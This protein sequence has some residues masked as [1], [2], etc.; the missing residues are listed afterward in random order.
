MTLI[1]KKSLENIWNVCDGDVDQIINRLST[2]EKRRKQNEF[3]EAVKEFKTAVE[4]L[5]TKFPCAS[6][7]IDTRSI[8][9]NADD[10]DI[11]RY[12]TGRAVNYNME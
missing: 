4:N 1:D 8:D 3:S 10:I 2:I 7:T 12:I 5:T 11:L 9:P 6:I